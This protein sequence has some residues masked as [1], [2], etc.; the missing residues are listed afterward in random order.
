MKKKENE[1]LPVHEDE[2]S[3]AFGG[4]PQLVRVH[5][6]FKGT[7]IFTRYFST[8]F[9][10]RNHAKEGARYVLSSRYQN[11]SIDPVIIEYPRRIS[12]EKIVRERISRRVFGSVLID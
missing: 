4:W 12:S 8:G 2:A 7:Q 3:T 1:K 6:E 11:F 10:N 5:G 9:F